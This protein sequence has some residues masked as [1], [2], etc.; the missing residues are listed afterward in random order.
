MVFVGFAVNPR[1][2]WPMEDGL[3]FKRHRARSEWIGKPCPYCGAEMKERGQRRVT[4]DH[5]HPKCRGGSGATGNKLVAC[6]LCNADKGALTL[7]EWLACLEARGEVNRPRRIVAIMARLAG[8][9]PEAPDAR[10]IAL[11]RFG[12]G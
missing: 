12:A 9:D 1:P 2:T 11:R 6:N 5:V 4:F 7:P 8:Y 3:A 10:L